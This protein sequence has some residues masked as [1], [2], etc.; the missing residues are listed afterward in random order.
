MLLV[1]RVNKVFIMLGSACNLK[2]SY[3]VQGK[4]C[5]ALPTFPDPCI[6]DFLERAA[7]NIA[8][9]QLRIVLYGGEP[10]IYLKQIKEIVEK[11]HE[12]NVN[13]SIITNG[14]LLDDEVVEWFNQNNVDVAVSWDGRKSMVTRGYDVVA[15]KREVLLKVKNLGFSGVLSG[16][17]MLSQMLDDF[18]SFDDE[19]HAAHGKHIN[20]NIDELILNGNQ[21]ELL[22]D[23][24]FAAVACD[25]ATMLDD[26]MS[27]KEKPYVKEAYL[28]RVFESLL[29]KKS[30]VGGIGKCRNG[31]FTINIDLSGNLYACHNVHEPIGHING[32]YADYYM[33]LVRGSETMKYV[34]VCMDCPVRD[35]C[36]GGCKL[37]TKEYRENG[38]CELRKALYTPVADFFMQVILP[39]MKEAQ[40]NGCNKWHVKCC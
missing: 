11:T 34:E 24:D 2:C 5:S 32:D 19:Y 9:K 37:V 23:I 16:A 6:F 39:K 22:T 35:L 21:P 10:L 20:V 33:K 36:R 18:Q 31:T 3:C 1:R 8:P 14:R 26:V 13:Y 27:K 15:D 4:G 40:N 38:F 25:M 12:L 7:K 17:T 29:N 30:F 28:T